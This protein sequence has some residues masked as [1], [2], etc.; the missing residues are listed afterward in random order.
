MLTDLPT[1]DMGAVLKV[2][3]MVSA[4]VQKVSYKFRNDLLNT[5]FGEIVCYH[6]F[7]YNGNSYVVFIAIYY[8][9]LEV[10]VN[11]IMLNLL[12]VIIRITGIQIQHTRASCRFLLVM[13][14]SRM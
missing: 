7:K 13:K 6:I 14:L 9:Y 11:L 1:N 8:K 2:F 12:H 4:Y 5:A 3:R 10:S